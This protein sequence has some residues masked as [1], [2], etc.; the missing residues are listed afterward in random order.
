MGNAPFEYCQVVVW[1]LC[2]GCR[3]TVLPDFS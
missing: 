2:E 3:K 1:G